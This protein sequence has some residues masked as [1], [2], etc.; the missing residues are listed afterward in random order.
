MSFVS[1]VA[2]VFNVLWYQ[3]ACVLLGQM[4]KG[5]SATFLQTSERGLLSQ[6]SCHRPAVMAELR[7]RGHNGSPP[8]RLQALLM[9]E[10]VTPWNV[11]HSL[12]LFIFTRN[13]RAQSLTLHYFC[14]PDFLYFSNFLFWMIQRSVDEKVQSWFIVCIQ[15]TTACMLTV[16]K[17]KL[18]N[19]FPWNQQLNLKMYVFFFMTRTG[20]EGILRL[21]HK[22]QQC[23]QGSKSCGEQKFLTYLNFVCTVWA[24]CFANNINHA[25]LASNQYHT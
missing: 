22:L 20:E 10:E 2:A 17:K 5:N 7:L 4:L 19:F 1:G 25:A 3:S 6:L 12:N 9:L 11:K 21:Q 24:V 15:I 8:E 16:A 23:V 13:T 14:C 18:A